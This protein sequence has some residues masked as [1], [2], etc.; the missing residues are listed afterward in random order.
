MNIIEI[1]WLQVN[2]LYIN[3]QGY[4]IESDDPARMSYGSIFAILP[5][6]ELRDFE[7][8]R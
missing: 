6:Q 8:V 4:E 1:L 3:L 5:A 7:H 2:D